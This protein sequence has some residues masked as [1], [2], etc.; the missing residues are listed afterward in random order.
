VNEGEVLAS[1]SNG[2]SVDDRLYNDNIE[3]SGK[4]KRKKIGG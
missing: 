2:R 1:E 4:E 3:I